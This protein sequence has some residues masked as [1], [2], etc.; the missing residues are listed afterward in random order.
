MPNQHMNENEVKDIIE[1]L[2]WVDENANLF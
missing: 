1:Y 2:K